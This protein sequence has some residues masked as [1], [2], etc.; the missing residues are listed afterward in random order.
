MKNISSKYLVAA[1]LFALT[2]WFSPAK[3]FMG[4][5]DVVTDP[6]LTGKVIAAEA[7]RYGQM[8]ESI[9]N[10]ITAYQNMVYNTLTLQNP[11]LKPF[12]DIARTAANTYYR[13][14]NLMYRA[15]NLDQAFGGM[16]PSY[17]NYQLYMMNVGRGGQTLEQKYRDWSDKGYDNVKSALAAAN[18]QAGNM[19][20]DT[21]MVEKLV[22]QANSTGGQ[23]QALQG[24]QQL[25]GNQSRQMSGL[26]ELVLTQVRMQANHYG[27][28]LERRTAF[29]ASLQNFKTPRSLSTGT[30]F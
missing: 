5:G 26:N 13:S 22:E 30:G 17:M 15:Q 10:Q 19:T 27:M 14:Q 25:M 29:D 20:K 11:A 24:L 21:E 7:T 6:I 18:I 2:G 23:M 9:S 28:E 3:A 16:Y 4:M 8:M 1:V 12:G